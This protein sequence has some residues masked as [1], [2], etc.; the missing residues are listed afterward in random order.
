MSLFC[1][2]SYE[3][4]PCCQLLLIKNTV[5]G[6]LA[7]L[8]QDAVTL[9]NKK[10]AVQSKLL[11]KLSEEPVKQI[12]TLLR[13]SVQKKLSPLTDLPWDSVPSR[14]GFWM[15]EKLI[16]IYG[17]PEYDA[18]PY[19]QKQKLSQLEFCLL[20]SVSASGEKEVIANVATRMLKSRYATFRPY[21]YHLIEEENNHIHM[22]AE[23]CAR[24]G[25]F[26]PVLYSYAQ[27]NLW[28]YPETG[29]L[30]TFA[31]VLIFEELGQ[32]LNEIMAK[33]EAL[34]ELVRSINRYHVQDEGRH[35]SFGRM[36]IRQFAEIT[37]LLVPKE[38]WANLQKH[39]AQY[40]ATRHHDYHNVNIYKMV[41]LNNALELRS[42]LIEGKNE[43]FFMKS[44]LASKRIDSLR[45]F[46]AEV[47]LLP[48]HPMHGVKVANIENQKEAIQ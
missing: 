21:F 37:Q 20:C 31:H 43:S 10:I 1:L 5:G 46:L 7:G 41:G 40:L 4:H 22:F 26:F 19:E 35:I 45:R 29:D 6:Y 44:P 33:D 36:L 9:A 27:G 32:G 3:T 23:F 47:Q 8:G 34:P 30:L 42:R 24:H 12:E 39:V 16:S 28:E 38:E 25:Q 13:T 17:E 14:D 48:A 18:L 11:L 15:S 2:R